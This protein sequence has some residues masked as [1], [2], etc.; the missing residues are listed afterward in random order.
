V[1]VQSAEEMALLLNTLKALP[2]G[3]LQSFRL[4]VPSPYLRVGAESLK[5]LILALSEHPIAFLGIGYLHTTSLGKRSDYCLDGDVAIETLVQKPSWYNHLEKLSITGC[6]VSERGVSMLAQRIP[7][8]GKLRTIS[9][10][11]NMLGDAG[12]L[13]LLRALHKSPHVQ[14]VDLMGNQMSV[15]DATWE[16]FCAKAGSINSAR[17][18]CGVP[19]LSLNLPYGGCA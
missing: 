9:L 2:R 6:S 17:R 15:K 5:Q 1:E 12:V 19:L 11:F 13:T 16:E 8:M 18:E 14:S 4:S 3:V 7:Q 10:G